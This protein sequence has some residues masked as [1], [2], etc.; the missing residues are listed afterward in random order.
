MDQQDRSGG[1]DLV[2]REVQRVDPGMEIGGDVTHVAGT[3]VRSGRESEGSWEGRPSVRCSGRPCHCQEDHRTGWE[4]GYP[5]AGNRSEGVEGGL[6]RRRQVAVRG[7]GQ[8]G[9]EARPG[10]PGQPERQHAHVPQ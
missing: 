5:Q 8:R 10:W 9:W 2:E 4:A 6:H 3:Q 1:D 7:M